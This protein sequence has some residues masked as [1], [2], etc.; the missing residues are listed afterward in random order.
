MI[1]SELEALQIDPNFEELRENLEGGI[2]GI[3]LNS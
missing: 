1:D 2:L 3:E